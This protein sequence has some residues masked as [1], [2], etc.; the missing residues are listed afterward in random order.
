MDSEA[1]LH[2]IAVLFDPALH[3]SA[4]QRSEADECVCPWLRLRTT[5][6]APLP[7]AVPV[8]GGTAGTFADSA[9]S[10]PLACLGNN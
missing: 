7:A 5:A 3:A 8:S 10:W 9:T 2:A 1:V 4:R 6:P